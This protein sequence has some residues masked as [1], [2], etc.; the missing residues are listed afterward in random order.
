MSLDIRWS[1]PNDSFYV[2][3]IIL[4]SSSVVLVEP[5]PELAVGSLTT[6]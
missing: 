3:A 5:P 4:T 6:C 2:R 1:H